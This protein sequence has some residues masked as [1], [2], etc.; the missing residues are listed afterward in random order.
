MLVQCNSVEYVSLFPFIY[1]KNCSH[2]EFW[3]VKICQNYFYCS[4]FVSKFIHFVSTLP[5][6]IKTCILLYYDTAVRINVLWPLLHK[7]WSTHTIVYH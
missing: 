6:I 7:S 4:V 2:A 1:E 3:A 5:T